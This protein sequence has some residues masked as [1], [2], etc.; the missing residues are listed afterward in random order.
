MQ[1]TMAELRRW[2]APIGHTHLRVTETR[3]GWNASCSCG[4]MTPRLPDQATGEQALADHA[5]RA[6]VKHFRQERA[7]GHTT[8]EVVASLEALA[9]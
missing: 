7:A 6:I 5:E 1:I 4:F 3:R 9:G 8:D 2:L